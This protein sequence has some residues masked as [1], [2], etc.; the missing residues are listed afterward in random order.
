MT[1]SKLLIIGLGSIAVYLALAVGLTLL[2]DPTFEIL[3]TAQPA[4]K[5]KRRR[6]MTRE[7]ARL[8]GAE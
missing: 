3:T 4:T 2:P 1:L 6:I 8:D 7:P 5:K